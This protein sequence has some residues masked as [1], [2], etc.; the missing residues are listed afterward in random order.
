[1]IV[2][3]SQVWIRSSKRVTHSG[4]KAKGYPDI[5]TRAFLH[6]LVEGSSQM[7]S[8]VPVY[9]LMD[10]DPDGL[11][12]QSTYAHG[13]SSLAH[14]AE[15]LAVPGMQWLGL[16]SSDIPTVDAGQSLMRLSKRDRRNAKKMLEWITF[17]DDRLGAEGR[18][19]LQRMLMLGCKA[20]IQILDERQE[21]LV[22][23]VRQRL[24]L[25]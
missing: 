15:N 21:G 12:I 24:G 19:E 6:Y 5:A 14:D 13:S 10:F 23:W 1:M 18:R 16:R 17:Q 11:A 4:P 25:A 2:T 9:G 22:G 8:K 7:F 3:V 20:E